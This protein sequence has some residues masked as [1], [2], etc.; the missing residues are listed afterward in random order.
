MLLVLSEEFVI[1]LSVD[2]IGEILPVIDRWF[3][4]SPARYKCL[5]FS[6][7]ISNDKFPN[8]PA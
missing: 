5:L 3:I 7:D 2:L 8:V 1:I 4:Q 6:N